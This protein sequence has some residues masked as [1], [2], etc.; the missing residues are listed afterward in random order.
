[1]AAPVPVSADVVSAMQTRYGRLRAPNNLNA[2]PLRLRA[3]N[4]NLGGFGSLRAHR[5]KETIEFRNEEPR[6][7]ALHRTNAA[8][9]FEFRHRGFEDIDR[10]FAADHIDPLPLR[11]DKDIVRIA[12][13][14][15]LRLA[16][17]AVRIEGDQLSGLTGH[18]E[19]FPAC[20]INRHREV[21]ANVQRPL[22]HLA[23]R[24]AVEHGDLTG[25]RHVRP[26]FCAC[27]I[28]LKAL[29]MPLQLN[30]PG[31]LTLGRINSCDGTAAISDINLVR[32]AIDPDIVGVLAELDPAY[33]R[34]IR[35]LE[36]TDRAVTRIRGVKRVARSEISDALRLFQ[37]R[38]PLDYLALG[39]IDDSDAVVAQFGDKK[40]FMREID[41]KV[42]D[43]ASDF[44]QRNFCFDRHRLGR[45]RSGK[46]QKQRGNK[47]NSPGKAHVGSDQKPRIHAKQL[48]PGSSASDCARAAFPNGSLPRK[49]NGVAALTSPRRGK[50]AQ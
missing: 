41:G 45:A 25:V 38:Q 49:F 14:F 34:K 39:K 17:A 40:P 1:M 43:A 8:H 6:T 26:Y 46:G 36:E 15:G 20:R 5:D 16:L 50:G 42:I 28:E 30:F 32:L 37:A 35:A 4:P 24:I 27:R 31:N 21:C 47:N 2:R 18:N 10:T 22:C 7:R 29:R 3:Q 12:A 44:P 11:I 9:A 48:P 13:S 33:G 23:L 19:N